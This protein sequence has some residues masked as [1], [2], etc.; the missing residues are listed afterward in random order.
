MNVDEETKTILAEY[1]NKA[2]SWRGSYLFSFFI[3]GM[4][5]VIFFVVSVYLGTK[6]Y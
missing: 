2:L 5:L 6:V 4:A 3:L 1:S